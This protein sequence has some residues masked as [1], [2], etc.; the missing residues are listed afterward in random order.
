MF[1]SVISTGRGAGRHPAGPP[2]IEGTA[3]DA[4]AAASRVNYHHAELEPR[5]AEGEVVVRR[6]EADRG[7]Q[8]RQRALETL[9]KPKRKRGL[10]KGI[11]NLGFPLGDLGKVPNKNTFAAVS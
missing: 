5:E 6:H 7:R 11:P 8:P 10:R 2:H 1:L 9:A 3:R 4:P